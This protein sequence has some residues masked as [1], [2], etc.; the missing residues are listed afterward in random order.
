LYISE[1][2]VKLVKPGTTEQ[3]AFQLCNRPA[4]NVIAKALRLLR[5]AENANNVTGA[6]YSVQMGVLGRFNYNS[7]EICQAFCKTANIKKKVIAEITWLNDNKNDNTIKDVLLSLRPNEEFLRSGYMFMDAADFSNLAC[8][9]YVDGYSIDISCTKFIEENKPSQGLIVYL[10]SYTPT[11]A[12]CEKDILHQ[13]LSPF[14]HCQGS[15]NILKIICPIHVNRMHWGL[16]YVDVAANVTYYDDGLHLAPPSNLTL[17]FNNVMM[18]L[19]S[20]YPQC[21]GLDNDRW[22]NITFKRFGMPLQPSQGEGSS[23]CGV[24]VIFATRDIIKQITPGMPKF[25]WS[26]NDSSDLRKQ[27]MQELISIRTNQ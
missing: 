22:K 23:S 25:M 6:N 8:E 13:K 26:F 24:G 11:W 16:L 3:D 19:R 9:R 21:V 4:E 7:L 15:H 2:Q 10:P 27:I 1:K 18:V 14:L 5:D 17:V 12:S 20:V